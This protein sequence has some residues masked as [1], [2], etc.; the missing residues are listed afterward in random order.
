MMRRRPKRKAGEV[1]VKTQELTFSDSS[2]S[3]I[4]HVKT[5]PIS[6]NPKLFNSNSSLDGLSNFQYTHFIGYQEIRALSSSLEVSFRDHLLNTFF[7]KSD[8]TC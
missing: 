8:I 1:S 4:D 2:S 7:L 6:G 3:I 5:W